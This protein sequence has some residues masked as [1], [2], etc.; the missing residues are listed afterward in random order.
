MSSHERAA[1]RKCTKCARITE[2]FSGRSSWC[3]DCINAYSKEHYRRNL[4][5]VLA[6][7]AKYR[8]ANKDAVKAAN[9]KWRSE[10]AERLRRY[11]SQY[12]EVNRE[13]LLAHKRRAHPAYYAKNKAAFLAKFIARRS[14]KERALPLWVDL[15]TIETLYQRAREM[16]EKTGIAHEVDHIVPLNNSVVCGLHVQDNLRVIT[17]D[18]NKRKRNRLIEDIV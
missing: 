13:A 14:L 1:I 15:K 4:A 5:K 17:R 6:R 7:K 2:E 12:R 16:T 8:I 18:E 9:A 11:L 10:N 3:K